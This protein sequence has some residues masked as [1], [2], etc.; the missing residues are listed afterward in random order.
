[1]HAESVLIL[2]FVVATTVAVAARRLHVPY[3]VALVLAGL[4]LGVLHVL[5]P[6]HLTKE[7]LFAVFLPGLVFEA[8]FH[9]K[10]SLFRRN[11]VAILSLAI[12]GVL[13][14]LVL[15]ALILVP[16]ARLLELREALTWR[17]ALVFGALIAA[18]DPIAVVGLFRSLGAPGR[19]AGLLEGESLLND[20][21]SIVFFGL[22]LSLATGAVVS[23]GIVVLTFFQVVGIG[24]LVGFVMGLTL[25]TVTQ[26][27]DDPMIEITLTTIAAYGSFLAA[28]QL[29]GSGVIATVVAGMLCGNYGARTGMSPSTR[30]AVETFWEYIAFALNSLVFLLIGFEVHVSELLASWQV[31]LSAFLAVMLGR[32][33]VVYGVAGL[34]AR[35]R[36]RIPPSWTAVLTWGGLRGGL[37]MVLALSLPAGFPNRDLLVATTFGV[38]LLSILVQGLS[39]GPLLRRLGIVGAG[40]DRQSYEIR[41]GELQAGQAALAELEMMVRAGTLS[42]SLAD[43]LRTEYQQRLAA[44]EEKLQELHTEKQH[45]R[46]DELRLARRHLLMVEK[47]QAIEALHQGMLG[48]EAYERVLSDIDGRLLHLEEGGPPEGGRGPGTGRESQG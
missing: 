31:I 1:M 21:T 18:T 20:G 42:K 24:A 16:A 23:T 38:V 2:L 41:R 26:R 27:I 35:S 37:S 46:E 8:A 33:V 28:E 34:M 32:A 47:E 3:T 5:E 11:Q 7:L 48:R 6:P 44:A 17:H 13:V 12:P 19:L 29:H 10:W 36:E 39:M 40:E 22:T 30:V 15:T 9:L 43:T 4:V 45:L 14:A 25:S